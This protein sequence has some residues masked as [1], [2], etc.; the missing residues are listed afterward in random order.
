MFGAVE[1]DSW[2]SIGRSIQREIG[3]EPATELERA[4]TLRR[5]RVDGLQ[6]PT[7]PAHIGCELKGSLQHF[8]E[9]L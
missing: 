1:D 3:M 4:G 6:P 2:I 9:F 8:G 7:T 5:R